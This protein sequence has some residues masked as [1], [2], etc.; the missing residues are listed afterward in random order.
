MPL[1]E[2]RC[3]GCGQRIEVLQHFSDAPLRECPHCGGTLKKLL[4]APALQFKGSGFYLTD[5]GRSGGRKG[6][7][8]GETG[9]GAK[10]AAPSVDSKPAAESKPPTD[11]KS[12]DKK[13]S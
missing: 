1:Y 6:D 9:E 3:T 2:Y 8:G 10:A 13:A 11:A 7:A 5:Y 4:S 12:S